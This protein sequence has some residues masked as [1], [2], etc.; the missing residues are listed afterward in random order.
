M[1][2]TPLRL[3]TNATKTNSAKTSS[4]S[5]STCAAKANVEATSIVHLQYADHRGI[6]T[7]K[8]ADLQNTLDAFAVQST[9]SLHLCASPPT[10]QRQNFL[11][12]C[13][14]TYRPTQR[15]LQTLKFSIGSDV[16]DRLKEYVFPERVFR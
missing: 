16:Q 13:A 12:L 3:T 6:A 9:W 2:S 15:P 14:T 10:R 8:E 1:E 4:L 11:S 7:H 5:Y